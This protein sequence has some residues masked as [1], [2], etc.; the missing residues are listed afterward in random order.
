MRDPD[1]YVLKPN[2]TISPDLGVISVWAE[3]VTAEHPKGTGKDFRLAMSTLDAMCLM[4]ILQA[5]Q[6]AYN[7]PNPVSIPREIP[8]PKG[9]QKN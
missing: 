1:V 5:M 7:L 2:A 9:G 3:T 6:Q 8:V 4:K